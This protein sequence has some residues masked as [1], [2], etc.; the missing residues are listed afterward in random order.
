MNP[1]WN[2]PQKPFQVFGNTYYVGTRGLASILITSQK[3]HVLIDGALP[4]SA[5]IIGAN[6]R[7]LGFRIEDVK[8]ILNSHDHFDHAGGIAELQRLSGA[9][10]AASA[11]S[12]KVLISG[13]A[14]NDDPQFGKLPPI[15]KNARVQVFKDG[16]RLTAGDLTLTAHLTPGHT[17]GGT[18]WSW[19]SCE[20][21]KC[22]NIVYADSMT[23]ISSD[24]YRYTDPKRHPNGEQQLKQSF[25]VLTA[26]PCDILLTPHPEFSNMF[27]KLAQR[28]GGSRYAF[29]D[30][31]SCKNYADA[32][33]ERLQK[34][35]NDEHSS[36]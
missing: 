23:P 9:R 18:S 13:E 8:L 28:D 7:A 16:E 30:S 17:Q 10:V 22:F 21:S 24:S 14:G 12:A 6:I 34:R 4:E 27:D 2:Q 25:A 19:Q 26:L 15:P 20:G 3:G 35:V 11:A 31:N 5:P 1:E 29:V 33:R 36:H 32:G